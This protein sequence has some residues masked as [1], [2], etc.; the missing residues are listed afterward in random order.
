MADQ[1]NRGCSGSRKPQFISRRDLLWKAGEGI[2]GLAFAYLLGQQ[3]LLA[4]DDVS[5]ACSA[6][7]GIESPL[8]PRAPHFKPAG[9]NRDLAVH[10]RRGEPCRHLRS[11]SRRCRS[12]TAAARQ[13]KGEIRVRQG[14]PGPLDEEPVQLQTVW[15]VGDLGLRAVSACRER[16]S[17]IWRSSIPARANPTTTC[18]PTTS[19]TPG[20]ILMGFP[21]RRLLGDLRARQRKPEPAGFCCDLRSRAAGPSAVRPTGARGFLPA[22]YQGT[23]FRSTG[24]PILDL[25]PPS[26]HVTPEQQRA[27]LDQLD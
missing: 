22:A 18:C 26:E 14:Y 6:T 23:V 5:A 9:Q 13:G 2:G 17:T 8:A 24:D 21:E 7:L 27:R 3:G 12:T 4:K 20:R 15:A 25:S 19:G 1:D 10:E 16:S 11:T